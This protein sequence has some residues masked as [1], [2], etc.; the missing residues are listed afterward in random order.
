MEEAAK[1]IY[2]WGIKQKVILIVRQNP[3]RMGIVSYQQ[4]WNKGPQLEV[5][6]FKW[7]YI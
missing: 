2:E 4:S 1:D 7:I 5:S 6:K 3:T